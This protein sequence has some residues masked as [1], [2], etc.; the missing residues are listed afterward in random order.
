[1]EMLVRVQLGDTGLMEIIRGNRVITPQIVRDAILGPEGAAQ[2]QQ[3]ALREAQLALREAELAGLEQRLSRQFVE[4][5]EQIERR[6]RQ[7]ARQEAQV[8]VAEVEGRIHRY[9]DTV[10]ADAEDRLTQ[11]PAPLEQDRI[12]VSRYMAQN[13]MPTDIDARLLFGQLLSAEMARRH[14]DVPREPFADTMRFVYRRHHE[15]VFD[16]VRDN[17]W[18]AAIALRVDRSI[19]AFDDLY[20]ARFPEDPVLKDRLRRRFADILPVK[21]RDAGM[22]PPQGPDGR[23]LWTDAHLGI[24]LAA[25]DAARE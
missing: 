11:Q 24:M 12:F 15:V 3:I 22:L 4:H 9:V 23:F 5:A 16:H 7:E 17:D 20:A 13:S 8:V 2:E 6:L 18:P 1:M 25:F 10:I 21:A 19:R 14:I